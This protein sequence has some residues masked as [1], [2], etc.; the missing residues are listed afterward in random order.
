MYSSSCSKTPFDNSKEDEDLSVTSPSIASDHLD[1]NYESEEDKVED[2]DIHET[3]RVMEVKMSKLKSKIS[4]RKL[5]LNSLIL[6]VFSR[7]ISHRATAEV[8]RIAFRG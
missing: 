1:P 2:N 3:C 7:K 5:N 4:I 8:C 6:E